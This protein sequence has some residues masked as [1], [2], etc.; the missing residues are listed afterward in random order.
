MFGLSFIKGT[1]LGLSL[2]VIA[3]LVLKN[4]ISKIKNNI[5]SS[6]QKK[7]EE[8]QNNEDETIN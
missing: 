2:G 6:S 5:S 3:G 4:T 1:I 8:T 7:V